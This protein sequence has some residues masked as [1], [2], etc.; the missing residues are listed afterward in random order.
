MTEVKSRNEGKVLQNEKNG[1]WT[2]KQGE[3]KE[4]TPFITFHLAL[5]KIRNQKV[6]SKKTV[7]MSNSSDLKSYLSTI[8]IKQRD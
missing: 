3:G 2:L 1:K 7:K 6:T 4:R 8:K 5:Y